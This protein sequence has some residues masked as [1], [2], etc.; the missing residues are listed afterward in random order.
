MPLAILAAFLDRHGRVEPAATI[1]GF[2]LNALTASSFSGVT[3][4][5]AHL[6]EVLGGQTYETLARAGQAITTAAMAT[7]AYDEIEQA[8]AELEQVKFG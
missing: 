2:A 1:A 4:A 6:R 3:V 5:I 8:R 7:Y